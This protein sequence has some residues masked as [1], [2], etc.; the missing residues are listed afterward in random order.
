METVQKLLIEGLRELGLETSDILVSKFI[1][2]LKELKKWNRAYNLTALKEDREIVIKHFLDSLLYLK[3]IPEGAWEICDVGSGAGFPGVPLAIVRPDLSFTLIEPSRKKT[4]FLRNIKRVLSLN[5]VDVLEARIEDVREKK[6]D[7][8]VTRALF[9]IGDF[10]KNA[11]HAV[12]TR[13]LLIMNKGPKFEEEIR[14]APAST[15]IEVLQAALP[16]SGI[17]RSIVKI[18]RS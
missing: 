5:N 9:S 3:A 10:I 17:Q 8:A 18:V 16:Q 2:Y 14:E 13:G 6:F 7:I 4:A 11:G 12:K 1:I 15:H